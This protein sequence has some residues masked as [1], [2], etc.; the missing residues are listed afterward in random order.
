MSHHKIE[1]GLVYAARKRARAHEA[2]LV[3]TLNGLIEQVRRLRHPS[4]E[5]RALLH[6]IRVLRNTL[7]LYAMPTM[8]V[9]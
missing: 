4:P 9:A 3:R 8:G 7:A 6:R 1:P 2:A 5:R